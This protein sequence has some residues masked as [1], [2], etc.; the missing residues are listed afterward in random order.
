VVLE[1]PRAVGAFNA[2]VFTL[3][4]TM[5]HNLS[6]HFLL[7]IYGVMCCTL[8]CGWHKG[9]PLASVPPFVF[10]GQSIAHNV[11]NISVR[12]AL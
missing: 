2:N 6:A 10:V 12:L 1:F 8:Q 4:L 7:L 9:M 5:K 11:S 3:N